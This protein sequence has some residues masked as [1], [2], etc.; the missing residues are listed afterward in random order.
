VSQ[1]LKEGT[2]TMKYQ[3]ADGLDA[4]LEYRYDWSNQKYF[5]THTP[6]VL[7]N[8]QPTV[9]LGLVWWYGGKQGAW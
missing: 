1:A 4:F 3:A 8:A 6:G 9:T 2:V 7:T 5:L